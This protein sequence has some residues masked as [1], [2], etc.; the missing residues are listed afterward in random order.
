MFD[1]PVTNTEASLLFLPETF[2]PVRR[3]KTV[4]NA[5][6]E[7]ECS[8]PLTSKSCKRNLE[9]HEWESNHLTQAGNIWMRRNLQINILSDYKVRMDI[10]LQDYYWAVLSPMSWWFLGHWANLKRFSESGRKH[11]RKSNLGHQKRWLDSNI[12]WT[13]T[14]LSL[15]FILWIW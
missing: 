14:A 1:F 2:L 7:A 4:P 11:G 3:V 8:S 6:C 9:A 13:R 5:T 10:L 15:G 12:L